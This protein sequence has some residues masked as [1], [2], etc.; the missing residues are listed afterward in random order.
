MGQTK[1]L[2][3]DFGILNP[4][5]EIMGESNQVLNKGQGE[6]HVL[7]TVGH[8]ELHLSL[9]WAMSLRSNQ[10]LFLVDQRRS[11]ISSVLGRYGNYGKLVLQRDLYQAS[12]SRIIWM[13]DIHATTRRQFLLWFPNLKDITY[14]LTFLFIW[15]SPYWILKNIHT[16]WFLQA[17][18]WLQ[19]CFCICG[20]IQVEVLGSTISPL[21][22]E[23]AMMGCV[24]YQ[25]K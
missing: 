4:T 6:L 2:L 13:T 14:D 22:F 20:N 12:L 3:L 10:G 17:W 23:P 8:R 25:S 1:S 15:H 11:L 19:F 9:I 18:L 7:N 16:Y 24:H 21:L 5:Q